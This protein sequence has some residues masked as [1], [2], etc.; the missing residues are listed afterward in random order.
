[1][2]FLKDKGL[3]SY[4]LKQKDILKYGHYFQSLTTTQNISIF[5]ADNPI[6]CIFSLYM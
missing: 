6:S 3:E 5:K 1:M 4:F 2:Y